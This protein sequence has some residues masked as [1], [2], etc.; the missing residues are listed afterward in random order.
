MTLTLFCA[1]Q[2]ALI[3]W[4]TVPRYS[5]A[6]RRFSRSLFKA[7]G[8]KD[9]S[10]L[11]EVTSLPNPSKDISKNAA[12]MCSFF[13]GVTQWKYISSFSQ[14]QWECLVSAWQL[15]LTAQQ[16]PW[17]WTVRGFDRGLKRQRSN[18]F[19][20]SENTKQS[21][22]KK[23]LVQLQVTCTKTKSEDKG[24]AHGSFHFQKMFQAWYSWYQGICMLICWFNCFCI[25]WL[26]IDFSTNYWK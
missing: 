16:M 25:H 18:L 22:E 7:R 9:T 4:C 10:C 8:K 21:I 1:F 20:I 3:F 5:L 24:K 13:R 14:K 2:P 17:R 23:T 6:H 11:T 19:S 26:Y 15:V 12:A